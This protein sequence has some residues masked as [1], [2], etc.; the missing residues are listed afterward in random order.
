MN[1]L[2]IKRETR[3]VKFQ[4]GFLPEADLIACNHDILV[5][6]VPGHHKNGRR[7]QAEYQVFF[8]ESAMT[9]SQAIQITVSVHKLLSFP[10]RQNAESEQIADT[11]MKNLFN[12]V[13]LSGAPSASSVHYGTE[14]DAGRMAVDRD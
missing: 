7:V 5:V 4:H 11:A 13:T 10:T 1:Q 3:K 14:T 8:A 12:L 6:K 9:D 2:T